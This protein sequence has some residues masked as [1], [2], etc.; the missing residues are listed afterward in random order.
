MEMT[1]L[2]GRIVS[3]VYV[4]VEFR[5]RKQSEIK[6]SEQTDIRFKFSSS[7]STDWQSFSPNEP[8]QPMFSSVFHVFVCNIFVIRCQFFPR[9]RSK[10]ME[11]GQTDIIF[12][13]SASRYIGWQ[14]FEPKRTE[15][16]Q[17]S[18]C[19]SISLLGPHRGYDGA[20]VP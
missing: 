14:K 6:D 18:N 3:F 1:N 13:I 20:R 15:P 8:N 9:N 17:I 5:N 11:S 10:N 4:D 19:F 12:K 2:Q 7:R 16:A